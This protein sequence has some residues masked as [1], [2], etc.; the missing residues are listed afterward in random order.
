MIHTY[1]EDSAQ[2]KKDISQRSVKVSSTKRTALSIR[3]LHHITLRKKSHFSQSRI[4]HRPF[5][6]FRP[7]QAVFRHIQPSQFI[8]ACQRKEQ[9]VVYPC[10]IRDDDAE[11]HKPPFCPSQNPLLSITKPP[12]ATRKTPFYRSQP[13]HPAALCP[14]LNTGQHS[15]GTHHRADDKR[16]TDTRRMSDG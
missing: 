14:F 11:T 5:T 9:M 12:F 3:Y 8:S 15:C 2:E 4:L 16:M 13:F 1:I 6:H 7:F 10:E